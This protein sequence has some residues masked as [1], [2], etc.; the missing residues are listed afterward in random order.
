MAPP[1]VWLNKSFSSTFNV[2]ETIREAEP[3]A[4]RI[5]CTHT[6]PHVPALKIADAAEAEP[7]NLDEGDYLAYCLDVVRR[8]G[9]AVFVPGKNL[10]SLAAA[11]G[12]FE[13]LGCRVVAAAEPETLDLLGDKARLY[14]ALEPGLVHVPAYRVVNDLVRLRRRLRR[15]EAP[16]PAGVLQAV[17]GRLRA[18]LSRPDR[19]GPRHRPAAGGRPG[20]DRPGRRPLLPGPA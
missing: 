9:V 11:R 8:H 17:R 5:L 15:A 7:K 16:L 1:T 2:V 19:V 4:F 18:G 12:R 14:A 10:R 3:G 6:N 13:A 20:Q